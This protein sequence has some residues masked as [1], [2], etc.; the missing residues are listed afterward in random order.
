MIEDKNI[1]NKEFKEENIVKTKNIFPE[2][3]KYLT[4]L[5]KVFRHEFRKNGFRR[6]STPFFEQIDFFAN[7][8]KDDLE[9]YVIKF[10][11]T[12]KWCIWLNPDHSIFNLN[13]Y[14]TGNRIEEIQPVYSYFMDRFYPKIG[15]N[16]IEWKAYFWGDIIWENDVIIDIQNLFIVI[17]I[18]DKIG[19]KWDYNIKYNYIWTKKEIDKY[20]EKLIDFYSD[21]KHLL[22][23]KS[24]KILESGNVL[25]LLKTDNEDE[26][27]LAKAAP[28]ISKSYKKD[29]KKEALKAIEFLELLWIDYEL[30]ELL[31]WDYD[32]NDWVIWEISLKTWKRIAFGAWYNELSNL[33]W[34]PKEIPWSWFWVDIFKIVEVLKTKDISIKNKDSLDLFFVQLWDDAKK[35]VFPLSIQAREAWIKTAVSLWTPSMK[36]QMLKA[37]RS[38]ATYVVM[39]WFM[40][41]KSWV[42]QVR[43]LEAWTQEE[44]KKEDLIEY[45]I[46]KIGKHSLDFYDPSKDLLK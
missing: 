40:E 21:K 26:Q 45:I 10:N 41:A 46:W 14:I 2:D 5:K 28:K 23:E 29:S 37:T 35:V 18:L 33:I 4:F 34:S 25:K 3:H 12:E 27:E 43:N 8:F 42:F 20:K 7:I 31:F 11:L 15:E 39:V 22:T 44:V 6:I 30:D 32:F 38:K 36:E 17:N 1:Q 9:D 19:L 16:S 24:L 13:A